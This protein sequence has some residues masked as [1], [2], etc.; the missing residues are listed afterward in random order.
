MNANKILLDLSTLT[1]MGHRGESYWFDKTLSAAPGDGLYKLTIQ[2]KNEA[3]QTLYLPLVDM[4]EY[5]FPTILKPADGSAVYESQPVMEWDK[6][7][8]ADSGFTRKTSSVR[9]YE[10]KGEST[11][12]E[13]RWGVN[14]LLD[15]VTRVQLGVTEGGEGESH[16][17]PGNY[18][19]WINCKKY[20]KFGGFQLVKSTRAFHRFR[21]S[22]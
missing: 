22:L 20:R 15:S 12:W 2:I 21:V 1:E 10:F 6:C 19:A 16:L 11:P 3:P 7:P 14:G 9:F 18:R 5:E 8:A 13:S 4:L 17:K